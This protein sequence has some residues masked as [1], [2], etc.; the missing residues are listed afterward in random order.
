M[1]R[2]ASV[3]DISLDDSYMACALA[4]GRR[5]LGLTA[6][7]PSVGA[8]VVKEGVVIGRGWTGVGGRPHAEVIA[9]KQAGALAVG[10]TLYV[11]L[12]PCAHHGVTPPCVES[13]VAAG[14][15][16]VVSALEDPNPRVAGQGHQYLRQ[17]GIEL[18]LGVGAAMAR[19]DHMGHI[20]RMMHHRPMVTLK[21][22]QTAD[23][24]AAGAAYDPRLHITGPV[25]DAFTHVQR[26]MHDAIMIGAG[27]AREDDPLMTVR[28]PGM[29]NRRPLRIVL[30]PKLS[31]SPRSRLVSTAHD[32]PLLIVVRE[33]IAD[34]VVL[35]FKKSSGA[36]VARIPSK[37]GLLN[38]HSVLRLLSERGVTRV[39]SEGGPTV[40]ESLLSAGLADEIILH[41]GVKPL[42]R[43]GKL[44]LTPAA[45][46]ILRDENKYR[47][48]EK[49]YLGVDQM[50][51][52]ARVD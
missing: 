1:T 30:D 16:R 51:R 47:L 17:S 37:D 49:R 34:E 24:Y 50:M 4:L 10:A 36:D 48:M 11:T 33:D 8:L 35:R 2:V 23:G 7:N 26:A 5:N 20:L 15:A 27:T 6:P 14:I 40:A 45:K 9:L 32:K 12:E 13:I 44:A 39:F 43:L 41:Q 38:L 25:A 18:L 31:L 19:L 3:P 22:A 21:L 42:G 52:Y 28:L 46:M 29:D